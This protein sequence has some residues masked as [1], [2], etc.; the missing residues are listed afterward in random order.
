MKLESVNGVTKKRMITLGSRA[1]EITTLT[2]AK[3]PRK[4]HFR[5]S[6]IIDLR[7]L[8]IGLNGG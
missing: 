1:K 6:I 8:T 4:K 2:K 3:I 7:E 5:D